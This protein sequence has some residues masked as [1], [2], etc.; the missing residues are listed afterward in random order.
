MVTISPNK[1]FFAKGVYNLSGKERLQWAQERISYIE[2]VIRY[3][4]EKEIP[5]INVYEKSLT[6]TGDGNL[7]Y[8]NPDDYIH[9]SA[10]GVDLI[11]KTIAEFIFSNNFFPQ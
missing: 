3:A 1:T 4:Q 10:E 5:L 11:S 9:P 7:K 2:A 6:P 8:I